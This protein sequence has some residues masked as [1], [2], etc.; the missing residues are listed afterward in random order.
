M[1]FKNVTITNK[2]T[3][4]MV[5]TFIAEKNL[6]CNAKEC[7]DYWEKKK[8][9]TKKKTEVKTLETA[10]NVYNS[11]AVQREVKRQLKNAKFKNKQERKKR[12]HEIIKTLQSINRLKVAP[13]STPYMP[14]KGQLSDERWVAFRQF[15]L[16]VRGEK[17]ESCGMTTGLQVHHLQYRNNAMA[18]EYNCNEVMVLCRDCHKKIHNIK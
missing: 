6:F 18:W 12:E 17:C 13:H 10:I 9:L 11:I 8:W 15:I 16:K 7:Y 1:K 4:A 14:Y 5:E 2:P 3:F